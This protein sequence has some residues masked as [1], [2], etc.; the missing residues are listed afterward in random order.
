M[1][2]AIENIYRSIKK[3]SVFL[4]QNA[5]TSR[6]KIFARGS[7]VF[8]SRNDISMVCCAKTRITRLK[9]TA[10]IDK[11]VHTRALFIS[12]DKQIAQRC[13]CANNTVYSRKKNATFTFRFYRV[14]FWQRIQ[15]EKVSPQFLR[16]QF[17]SNF[18]YL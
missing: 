4:A 3:L 15:F 13:F 8:I 2:F 12:V 6:R 16:G 11:N 10:G 7:I 14:R 5:C 17:F 9:Q 1:E 18:F